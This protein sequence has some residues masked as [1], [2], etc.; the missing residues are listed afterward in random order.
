MLH[1]FKEE[2]LVKRAMLIIVV[3]AIFLSGT[4]NALVTKTFDDVKTEVEVRL[5][6]L[7]TDD[8]TKDEKKEKKTLDKTLKLF[9][10]ESTTSKKDVKLIQKIVKNLDKQYPLDVDMQDLLRSSLDAFLGE[11]NVNLDH[12]QKRHD[13]LDETNKKKNAATKKMDKAN[14]DSAAAGLETILKQKSKLV[15]KSESSTAAAGKATSKALGKQETTEHEKHF[16][17][18]MPGA[19]EGA[20]TCITCHPTAGTE[21]LVSNHWLWAGITKNV[22]GH[23]SHAHGKRDLINNFCIAIPSNEGRCTQCHPG[24]GYKDDSFDFANQDALDCLICHDTTGK[25]AKDKKTAGLPV[26]GIDLTVVA[27]NVGEPGRANCGACHFGAGGG[28]NVKRGDLG[29]SLLA[30]TMDADVH[31]GSVATGGTDMSCQTCHVTSQHQIPG[32]QLQDRGRVAC[33]DCHD[34]ADLSGSSHSTSHLAAIA[35]QACHIKTFS[36]QLPT[37]V[38]WDWSTAGQDIDPI[39]VDKYGKPLYNKLK[40]T[41]VWEQNVTPE[42]LWYNGTWDRMFIGEND[43]YTETP[44]RLAAPLGTK[45]DGMLFPFKV[46]TGVQGADADPANH[47]VLIPHLFGLAGGPNPY[48]VK[49]DWHLAFV[50]GAAYTGQT[51]SGKY[52]W[53]ETVMYLPIN[54]EVAPKGEARSCNDCHN[55]GIDLWGLG[56]THDPMTGTDLDPD[57]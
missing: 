12:Y 17:G 45:G 26:P 37:K 51:Y 29:S 49:F 4:A 13:V 16:L 3:L 36:R 32:N 24:Y 31:M 41:F 21:M 7:P 11:L 38:D 39:P 5:G 1:T 19:Y 10:K 33:T 47:T 28:D 34:K 27:A 15:K 43:Q 35:C 6:D 30:P 44:V 57:K 20:G 55:G 8:L 23:E 52:E 54:H 18:E 22:P 48:W 50:D 40:G 56:Y 14:V 53:V 9:D 2:W 25:Y 46:M 42:L